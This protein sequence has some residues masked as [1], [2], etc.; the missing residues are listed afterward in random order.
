[1]V[2]KSIAKMYTNIHKPTDYT[3]VFYSLNGL[4][5]TTMQGMVAWRRSR[6][7]QRQRWE[8]DITDIFGTM[9]TA[10]RVG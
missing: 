5:K 8:K 6:G 4:E 1:M 2:A 7:K 10:T 9:T 3:I